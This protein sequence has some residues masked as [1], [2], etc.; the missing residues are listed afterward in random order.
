[1]QLQWRWRNFC[2]FCSAAQKPFFSFCVNGATLA[3]Q[4]MPAAGPRP[5]FFTQWILPQMTARKQ[6]TP[7]T[8]QTDTKGCLKMIS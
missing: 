1:M 6:P 4:N 7:K 3:N 8:P 5:R 2:P